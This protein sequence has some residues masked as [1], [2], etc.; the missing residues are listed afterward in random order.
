MKVDKFPHVN[1][2]Y[3]VFVGLAG[4]AALLSIAGLITAQVYGEWSN[5]QAISGGW[6]WP[7]VF[8]LDFI[9]VLLTAALYWKIYYDSKT[10]IDDNE[11]YQ[12]SLF[13]TRTISWSKVTK[14][15][16]FGGAGYHI[17]AG[18]KKIVITPYAYKNPVGVIQAIDAYSLVEADG[19]T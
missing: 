10:T 17:Y 9:C 15:E 8:T 5:G 11:I 4:T 3:I 13:G 14:I 1:W 19:S 16:V 6:S 7:I 2:L 18:D 12:P